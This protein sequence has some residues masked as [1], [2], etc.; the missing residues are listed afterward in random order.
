MSDNLFAMHGNKANQMKVEKYSS[1]DALQ[2]IIA[3]NPDLLSRSWESDQQTK[4]FLVKREQPTKI[5]EDHGK[6][7]SL[8]HLM[9]DE[10]GIPVLVEV[11]RRSDTRIRREVAAQM[12]DYACRASTWTIP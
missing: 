3:D 5:E 9:V 1:E 12:L 11:K 4:L 2:R 7:F 8:D 10:E 6:C